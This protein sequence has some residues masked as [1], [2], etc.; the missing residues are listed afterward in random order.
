VGLRGGTFTAVTQGQGYRI[1]L[2]Q[3]RWT[4]DLSVSGRIDWPGRSGVV[5]AAVE[6]HSLHK[7][8]PLDLSW[9]AGTA[10]ARANARG[11]LGGKKIL[12][13]AAAP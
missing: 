6:V 10:G 7:S 5:H 2:Q 12:A 4:E 13:E 9:M 8:G 1:T 3:A 11:R